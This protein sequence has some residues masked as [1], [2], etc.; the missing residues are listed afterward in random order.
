MNKPTKYSIALLVILTL[1]NADTTDLGE[2]EIISANKTKQSIKKT[3]SNVTVITEEDIRQN[4]YAS[5][6][7]ALS[8]ALGMN[9]S[10]NGGIGQ[11]DS[12][13]LRGLDS[14]K[15]LVL[16]DGIRLNDPS[17]TNNTAMIEFLP[18]SNIEQIEVIRGGSSSIWG[19]NASAGV[20]NII[21]K[22]GK[23]DGVSGSIGLNSG[24]H[25]TKGGKLSLFYKNDKLNAKLL[26]SYFDTDGISALAPQNSEKDRYNNKNII[27]GF[28]YD[29]TDKTNASLTVMK[30]KT[31]GDFDDPNGGGANDDYSNFTT[32]STNATGIISTKFGAID[33]ILNISRGEYDRIYFNASF[34]KD[35]YMATTNEYSLINSYSYALGKSVLGLEYKNIDGYNKNIFSLADNGFSNRAVFLSNAIKPIEKLLVEA[36]LRYDDFNEFDGKTTYKIGAKYT[37]SNDFTLNANY[38]TSFN[39]PSVYQLA[40]TLVGTTLKPSF[41][42][43][44]DASLS[45]KDYL[46]LTYFDNK[47]ED[48]FIYT[49]SWPNS[50]YANN[51]SSEKIRGIEVL[52]KSNTIADRFMFKANYTHLIDMKDTSGTPLYN[53]AK[54]EFNGWV[55][56]FYN[57][58]TIA[59]LNAQY[60]GKRHSPF[61]YPT[62][63]MP[64]GNYTLWNIDITKSFNDSIDF[65]LH[66]KNI[67]DKDYQTIYNY[68]SEGRSVYADVRYKF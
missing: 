26:S 58:D 32:D 19:A 65:G 2:I 35:A 6:P 37:L 49:G 13:F 20:I 64:S 27:A 10:Q 18:I 21:T 12:F 47:I 1:S 33:T 56:Y 5:V 36:N 50:G 46:S 61:G 44:H 63:P 41:V 15:I 55:E 40:N 30:T 22:N 8:T 67:F 9:V 25:N 23:K 51:A 38:Y 39:A 45:Y 31:K 59:S 52:A 60:I 48:D 43:G 68:N 34:G 66:F 7:E 24:S 14:G 4:G 11:K 17:T 54:D 16:V 62:S 57:E 29:F 42:K 53:R 28:G 3:T